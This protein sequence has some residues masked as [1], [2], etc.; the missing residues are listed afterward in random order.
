MVKNEYL[1][2]TLCALLIMALCIGMNLV[3]KILVIVN[4]VL[5]IINSIVRIINSK[6]GAK[7]DE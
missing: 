1:L 3:L 5:L 7:A 4:A 2:I 6:K